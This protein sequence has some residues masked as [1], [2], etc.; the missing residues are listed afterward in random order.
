[1]ST[2]VL[3]VLRIQVLVCSMLPISHNECRCILIYKLGC[4]FISLLVKH[5]YT[6]RGRC[7]LFT[8]YLSLGRGLAVT[9]RT[10]DIGQNVLQS[11]FETGSS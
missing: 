1:M 8:G 7:E 9:G 11:S 4:N 6:D 5:V 10:C 2:V 3:L